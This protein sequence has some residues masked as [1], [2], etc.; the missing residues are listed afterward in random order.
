MAP[1][2]PWQVFAWLVTGMMG[3]GTGIIGWA[4][5]RGNQTA[6]YEALAKALEMHLA[7]DEKLGDQIAA[8]L[9]QVGGILSIIQRNQAVIMDRMGIHGDR[10]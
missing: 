7:R 2:V 4:V 8:R 6:K 1:D 10:P 9:E 5:W 3:V